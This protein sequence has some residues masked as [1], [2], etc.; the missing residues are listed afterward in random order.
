MLNAAELSAPGLS[1][2]EEPHCMGFNTVLDSG[3]AGQVMH[4]PEVPG[5]EAIAGGCLLATNGQLIH[6]RSE[7]GRN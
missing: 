6:F 2:V 3:A 5:H 1:A 7:T 4:R